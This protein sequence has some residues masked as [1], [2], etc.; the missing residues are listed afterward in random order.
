MTQTRILLAALALVSALTTPAQRL[1]RPTPKAARRPAVAAVVLP[2][3]DTVAAPP[4]DSVVV[5]GFDKPCRVGRETM[6]VV[7]NTSRHIDDINFVINYFDMQQ[8]RL[9]AAEHTV[10]IDVPPGETRLVTVQSFDRNGMF[11]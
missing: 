5:V 11:Y 7:N 10:A 3:A 4:V 6:F 2:A 8:R 1:S 9:H